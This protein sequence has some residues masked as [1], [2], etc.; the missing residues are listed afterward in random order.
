M[1]NML[2]T[3][4]QQFIHKSRYARWIDDEQR[5]ENWDETVSRY[6]SFM[7]NHVRD[8]HGYKL[9]NSLKSEIT[10]GIMSLAVM[11]SMRAMM[12][13]GPA[14]A[15]D[16]ICGYNCSYIPVDNPRSFDECMYILMCG[17]GVGF[18]VERENVDKLPV[19]SDAM[20]DSDTVIKVGDSKPGW[21]KSL[22]ELIG[23]LYVGQIPKWDLS[24]VRASGERLKT[25]GG[26]ASGPGPLDDLFKFTVSMFK[27]AQGR[28][29]FPIECHDLMCKIGE[30]VVVGGVR[31]S[32]LIS[33]SNLND[34]QMAHAKSGMWWEHEGQRALANNSVAYKGKPEMGTF[35]REWLALYDS[36]SGERGIFNREAAD[37]QVARNGRREV[38]HMWGTNPCSEIIL[39]PYQ[40]CNL[41]EVVV[42]ESDTLESLKEK[43]RLATILGTL[44]ST[45][46]DFKYLRKVWR[47][48]TE[49][50]RLLG[51]SLTGIMDH[52]ILS[53]T[54]DSPRWLEEMRQV[55]VDT[56]KEYAEKLGIPQ[57]AAITCVKPSG[58]V[59]QLV[60]AA[61]GIHARHNDY[62][63][64]T[65]RGDNKDPLTQFLKDRGVHNEACVM[66]PDSTTVFS[67][68][69]KSP[70]N[71]VTRTQMTAIEQL[72]LWKVYALSWCEHK[73]SVTI[74]VKEHE[75]MDVGAWV[76]ENF[77]VASG[78]SFLP[79]SDHTY[80]QAPYQD[81]EADDYAE[82]QLAYGG[83]QIDWAA[84]SEYE[85]E[86]NTS[87]SR[88]LACTAGVCEVVDLNAA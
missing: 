79:H 40:F 21:A 54:V 42:R 58:T 48:N 28:K 64:R 20:H 19:V 38:G 33:L 65:V 7:D 34:D 49:E 84:L 24:G 45:L 6:V 18:S 14:L 41:S 23:L 61:S 59:S 52:P 2:P 55:A 32:A 25:M 11:P 82:W 57:S 50:E 80:Q 37:V 70:D 9:P 71:A 72:E 3:P 67:F 56:N 68:A 8:N 69:M 26:R 27:K 78:V 47:T 4:Y 31:R 12:T 81:I 35:M 51:V 17:T 75:W 53:K 85:R 60:D 46:T 66:K 76:Y 5:R 43:V 87:G 39:R 13:S 44:Q 83:L 86:D 36:K 29:L 88:E 73:P 1:N 77:D 74:T 16:N 22:R 10:D 30:I 15:R 63:I 62:Y